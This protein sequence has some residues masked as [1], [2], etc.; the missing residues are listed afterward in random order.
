M[1]HSSPGIAETLQGH[2]VQMPFNV[3]SW[4][5]QRMAMCINMYKQV[6]TYP[7]SFQSEKKLI[8]FHYPNI[9]QLLPQILLLCQCDGNR[10]PT[11]PNK[12]HNKKSIYC[13]IYCGVSMMLLSKIFLA[14]TTLVHLVHFPA[15]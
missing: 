15:V 12:Y 11:S 14:T 3:D 7:S 5:D 9:F 13:H 10:L 1:G 8:S 6:A 2:K 4:F